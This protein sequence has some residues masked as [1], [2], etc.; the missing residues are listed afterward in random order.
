MPAP[1]RHGAIHG[2]GKLREDGVGFRGKEE[3]GEG[4]LAQGASKCLRQAVGLL[5]QLQPRSVP[6]HPAPGSRD[7]PHLGGELA[8]SLHPVIELDRQPIVEHDH[9]LAQAA[10]ELCESQ[11]K[12]IDAGFPRH[13]RRR[14]TQ[15]GDGV[16]K[17][18]T[19]HVCRQVQIM[20]GF[21][22]RANL[23]QGVDRP[24][25]GRLCDGEGPALRKMEIPPEVN[26]PLD[27]FR[28]Q[29]G[30]FA[31]TTDQFRAS[32]EKLRRS[33]LVG[34]DVRLLMANYG[35]IAVTNRRKRQRVR[36]RAVEDKEDLGLVFEQGP[37]P[38]AGLGR[39]TIVPVRAD[40]SVIRLRQHRPS[41]R[42]DPGR[43]VAGKGV[44]VG[45][46]G[47]FHEGVLTG[48]GVVEASTR[49]GRWRHQ[50]DGAGMQ[51]SRTP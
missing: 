27:G 35:V 45:F 46:G 48:S 9:R 44:V 6:E 13:L 36:R 12:D 42:A 4:K 15:P 30:V 26:G 17:A 18:R 21:R 1:G 29:F 25:L 33:A 50:T 23:F 2:L 11:T 41:L 49:M 16:G 14:T 31:R 5:R 34:H 51:S 24:E 20:R 37:Q 19:I 10:A 22:E 38:L 43:V 28:R 8:C 47:D 32:G 3:V 40:R 39:V 7:Q